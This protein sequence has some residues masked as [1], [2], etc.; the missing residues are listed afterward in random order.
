MIVRAELVDVDTSELS[1]S[2]TLPPKLPTSIIAEHLGSQL[3]LLES[4]KQD[5]KAKVKE[6]LFVTLKALYEKYI[7]SEKAPLEINIDGK[8]RE[9][10]YKTFN[11]DSTK[12]KPGKVLRLFENAAED[13]AFLMNGS[14]TRYGAYVVQVSSTDS[15]ISP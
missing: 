4:L 9:S 13:T 2:V 12:F 8:Q 1:F 11:E 5:D 6:A 7:D 3:N 10:F 14:M 15:I